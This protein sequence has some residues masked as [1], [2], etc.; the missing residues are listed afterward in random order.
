MHFKLLRKIFTGIFIRCFSC[1]MIVSLQVIFFLFVLSWDGKGSCFH[2]PLHFD[3]NSPYVNALSAG[4][5]SIEKPGSICLR[6]QEVKRLSR[7]EVLITSQHKTVFLSAAK[8]ILGKNK[9]ISILYSRTV[10]SSLGGWGPHSCGDKISATQQVRECMG[11][12]VRAGA[13]GRLIYLTLH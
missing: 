9:Y 7:K 3:G 6:E 4:S 10:G 2:F 13:H 5:T 8:L 1:V 11:V 12:S